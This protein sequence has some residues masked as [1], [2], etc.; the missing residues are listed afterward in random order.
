MQLTDVGGYDPISDNL[1]TQIIGPRVIKAAL[2]PEPVSRL[3]AAALPPCRC[4]THRVAQK[5]P[6]ERG[7]SAVIRMIRQ[8]P[9][10]AASAGA[11]ATLRIAAWE[12]G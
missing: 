4:C 5:M 3:L 10:R 1:E 12:I 9:A 7:R 8:P 6:S 2:L 11:D